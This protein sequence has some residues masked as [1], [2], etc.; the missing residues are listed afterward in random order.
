MTEDVM[1][2]A[3]GGLRLITLNRPKFNMM[4]IAMM[5]ELNGRL[6]ELLSDENLKCLALLKANTFAPE[7]K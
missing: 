7:W 2:S 4:N 1:L 5:D 3:H 6:E